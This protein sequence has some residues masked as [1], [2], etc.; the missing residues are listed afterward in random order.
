VA[1]KLAEV[2]VETL[3]ASF[4]TIGATYEESEKVM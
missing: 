3:T 4:T 1:K 2:T